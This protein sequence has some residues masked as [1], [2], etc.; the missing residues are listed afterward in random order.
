MRDLR[1]SG[2]NEDMDQAEDSQYHHFVIGP[3]RKLTCWAMYAPP[4]CVE[5]TGLIGVRGGIHHLRMGGQ[6]S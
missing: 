5:S 6:G 4:E 1:L 3:V 2:G